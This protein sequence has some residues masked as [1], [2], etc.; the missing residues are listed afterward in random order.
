MLRKLKVIMSKVAIKTVTLKNALKDYKKNIP[1]ELSDTKSTVI[2]FNKENKDLL[3]FLNEQIPLTDAQKSK[4]SGFLFGGDKLASAQVNSVNSFYNTLAFINDATEPVLEIKIGSKW[5]P[6]MANLSKWKGMTGAWMC[7]LHLRGGLGA[8]DYE[9]NHLFGEW[10]FEDNSGKIVN[11]S[12]D[13]ALVK[14]DVRIAS[15]ESVERSRLLNKKI[16]ELWTQA[17]QIYDSTGTGLI[18]GYFG[19]QEVNVGHRGSPVT[20]IVEPSLENQYHNHDMHVIEGWQLPFVRVFSLRHKN[21]VF[22]DIEELN[23]HVF[24]RDNKKN[25]VLPDQMLTALESVFTANSNEIFGDLF[26]GR[27]GGIVILANGPSGVGKTLTAEVFAE[28]QER[29]LY[30]MEMSEVGTSLKEVEQNLQRIFARAKKWNAVLL[31]DEADIFLSERVSSDLERSAI[32]GIFLRLLDYYEGTFFLTTNR[33]GEIDKAF[34]SRVTL[35]LNYPEL[36]AKT[37]HTIWIN[38]LKSA[39]LSIMVDPDIWLKV[40]ETPLN[41][42]QIRNQ[43]RLLK[44][45]YPSGNFNAQDILDSLAF[46]AV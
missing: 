38:M 8:M 3:E 19:W 20:V 27:H 33:G 39:D 21:Y 42:R 10:N 46:A 4:I 44:L 30:V 12:I 34:K 24:H 11:K 14:Y 40:V 22:T 9:K 15:K 16:L 36:T 13:E 31:F 32:V 26:A 25:I 23:T 1:I 29:P 17:G 45:M 5:Y 2:P 37:R 41:G 18:L 7:E 28:Y 35:Y 43:V 6:V